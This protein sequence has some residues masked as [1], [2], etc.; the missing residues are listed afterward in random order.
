MI[1]VN[2]LLRLLALV[3]LRK[4]ALAITP[5]KFDFGSILDA[6]TERLE[7][8]TLLLQNASKFPSFASVV[9]SLGVDFD[10]VTDDHSQ[11]CLALIPG[12]EDDARKSIS[13]LLTSK[14]S[15]RI[16]KLIVFN[17]APFEFNLDPLPL[18]ASF[19]VIVYIS[20]SEDEDQSNASGRP[21]YV[22][23]GGVRQK[24]SLFQSLKSWSGGCCA[25]GEIPL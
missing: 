6:E 25:Q 13:R 7:F 21:N 9:P 22:K 3:S 20:T 14:A 4:E 17:V 12:G 16:D 8:S 23:M 10:K 1:I 5:I 15:E 2:L 24:K 18:N 11:F 19:P